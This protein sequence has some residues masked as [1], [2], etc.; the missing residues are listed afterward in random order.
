MNRKINV[1]KVSSI[2]LMFLVAG[3]FIFN[4]VNEVKPIKIGDFE[5]KK[6]NLNS[7]NKLIEEKNF[8]IVN[9]FDIETSSSI[10][11]NR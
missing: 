9:I 1:W 2:C 6:A 3:L 7:I 4:I 5:I 8:G 10:N 11:L